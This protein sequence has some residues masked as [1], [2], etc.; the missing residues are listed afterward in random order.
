[1]DNKNSNPNQQYQDI[2]NQY[3]KDI[4]ADQSSQNVPEANLM[5]EPEDPKLA[6]NGNIEPELELKAN[7][8]RVYDIPIEETPILP[9]SEQP[10]ENPEPPPVLLTPETTVDPIENPEPAPTR[11]EDLD[12]PPVS[13]VAQTTMGAP[14]NNNIFKISFFISLFVFI[15]IVVGIGFNLLNSNQKTEEVVSTPEITATPTA[16]LSICS[17]N[18]KQY[19]ENE[20]FPSADGCNTCSCAA[21]GN[22]VCTEKA[23]DSTVSATSKI[24][25]TKTATTSSQKASLL[26]ISDIQMT[27]PSGWT[28]T[29][30]VKN[31]AKILTDYK[32]YKVSLIL[33]LD[34]DN[35]AAESAYRS[36]S[37]VT[38]IQGGEV[39]NV[40]SGGTIGSTGALLNNKKYL[41]NWT[42]E[43]N[44]PVPKDL[45]QVWVPE[46]DITDKLLLSITESIK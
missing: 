32:K 1:M 20:S 38:K 7:V 10:I 11:V 9:M 42:I 14:K 45:D 29:S 6:L 34:K 43:S 25:P 36:K 37:S 31:T 5:I 13:P 41:F 8:D 33:N 12:L 35:A 19:Q 18:D 24:T 22:I 3:S 44:Q 27:L 46:S 21:N 28:V 26:K 39:F 17:L 23:C 30:V 15:C 40:A 2:L 16:V 4:K